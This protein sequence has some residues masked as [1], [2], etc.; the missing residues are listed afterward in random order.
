MTEQKLKGQATPEQ[1]EEWKKKHGQVKGLIVDGHIC[2]LKKPDRK[3][4]SFATVAGQKDPLKFN[5]ILLNNCWL[6]G[7]EEIKTDDD[8]FLSAGAKISELITVKEAELV[9]L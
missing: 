7:S 5:E 4:L 3:T 9:N 2:Y 1:I 6:G 8:L